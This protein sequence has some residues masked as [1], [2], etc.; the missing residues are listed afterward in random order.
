M[1]GACREAG[2]LFPMLGSFPAEVR[3]DHVSADLLSVMAR[4]CANRTVVVGAQSGSDATLRLMR[5]GH[6]VDDNL[7]A[8]RLVAEAG[9]VP[10]VDLLFGFP[11]E[12]RGDRLASLDLAR[13]V[14]SYRESRLHL[15]AYLPL[16]GASAWPAEPEPI[17]PEIVASLR[18]LK[19]T[20]R[21]DGYWDQQ[22]AQGRRIVDLL[23]AGV[24]SERPHPLA[25]RARYSV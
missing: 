8:V 9:L 15:H 3:P 19:D 11:G 4:H 6:G 25:T 5:R 10:H 14:L 22:V 20:G 21:V 12:T 24:I 18:A 13:G 2:A 16:P 17:E 7:R 23:R 1:L